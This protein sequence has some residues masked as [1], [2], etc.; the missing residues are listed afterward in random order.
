MSRLVTCPICER[1]EDSPESVRAHISAKRDE[2]HRGES[3][4]EYDEI[5]GIGTG[6]NTKLTGSEQSLSSAE[7]GDGDS[8]DT[9][10]DPE[11]E[12]G[13]GTGPTTV[14]TVKSVE[15]DEDEDGNEL[16]KLTLYGAGAYAL[17]KFLAG[18]S[19]DENREVM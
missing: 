18:Q 16:V 7:T 4:F 17:A 11:P 12:P 19:G 14:P 2:A 15:Q 6:S 13:Q 10:L 1:Y 9:D 8:P 3:G 5:L